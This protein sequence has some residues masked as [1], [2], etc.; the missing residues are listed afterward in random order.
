MTLTQSLKG[1][2]KV[3]RCCLFAKINATKHLCFTVT[4]PWPWPV[5]AHEQPI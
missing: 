3:I 1:N 2:W 4:W 5:S